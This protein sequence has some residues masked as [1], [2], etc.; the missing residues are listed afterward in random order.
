MARALPPRRGWAIT[1][2]AALAV[3]QVAAARTQ[4]PLPPLLSQTGLYADLRAGRLAPGV[5]GFTPQYPLWSDGSRKARWMWLPP[6][7]RIDASRADAWQF[8]PGTRLWKE[9]SMGRRV[10]TR[11]IER[12]DD[13]QWRYATYVWREDGSDAEL[14]GEEGIPA[15]PVAAAPGGRYRILA[16]AD[17]RAC[18]EAAAVPVLGVSALQL[19]PDRD[20]NAANALPPRPGDVDLPALQARGLLHGLDRRLLASPPRIAARAP[21]ERA[22][23]GYLHGNCGHCHNRDGAEPRLPLDLVLAQ[24][25]RAMQPA[26]AVVAA[27]LRTPLRYRRPG[28]EH[29]LVPGDP[30][31]S[32]LAQRPAS[33]DPNVRMPPL[34]TSVPD[35]AGLALLA[36]WIGELPAPT[37]TQGEVR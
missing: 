26:D 2:A 11:L 29:L 10:E 32:V 9:F 37:A 3:L 18:H 13:G 8:P 27:L 35:P 25:A 15:H 5:L 4:P 28:A 36:R 19:S 24:P 6:G 21:T 22:A 23:L 7:A 12:L 14:A 31:H 16:R 33:T 1:A 30:A 17:C 20:P 34:G